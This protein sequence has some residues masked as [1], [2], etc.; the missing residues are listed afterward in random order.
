MRDPTSAESGN[1]YAKKAAVILHKYQEIGRAMQNDAG[2]WI[3]ARD[4]YMARQSHDMFK[5]RGKGPNGDFPAWRDY[6]TPRLDE[7]TFA[8]M[9]SA[10][11]RN[12]FL[13]NVW[14]ALSSG[15]HDTS[16]AP[17]VMGF[18]FTGPGSLAKRVSQERK[19]HF[20][21]ADAW[22][23]YNT[24]FGKGSVMDA[25]MA[26]FHRTARDTALMRT[27]G[28]NP[29]AMYD[30][31]KKR[32]IKDATERNDFAAVKGMEQDRN[33]RIFDT[34]T[35]KADLPGHSTSA[36]IA[37]GIRM[38]MQMSHLGYSMVA[39]IVDIGPSSAM[40]RHNGI[41]YAESMFKQVKGFFPRGADTDR[42]LTLSGVGND[43][44]LS[45][46]WSSVRAEDLML[47]KM[48]KA[49]SNF[50]K[51]SGLTLWTDMEKRSSAAMLMSDLA[52]DADKTL[53]QL[54]R[55]RQTTLRRY[56]IGPEEWD[57]ARA[58]KKTAADG[59]NYILP[60]HIEDQKVGDRFLNYIIDQT[61]EGMSEATAS[62]RTAVNLNTKSGTLIGETVRLAMQF[63]S[64]TFNYMMRSIG[65][66]LYRD[67]VDVGG[68]VKMIAATT[69]LGAISLTL[70][71]MFKGRN[72]RRPETIED[73]GAFLVAAMLKGGGLGLYGDFILGNNNGFGGGFLET[74][75][76][77]TLTTV[78]QVGRALAN[79]REGQSKR[80]RLE[81]LASDM[82][83]I[84]VTNT[85][86]LN[87]FYTQA[88][89]NYLI[90]YR[91]QEALNSGYLQRYE[92]KVQ[93]ANAQTHWLP[94]TGAL[95][96]WPGA[97]PR[98]PSIFGGP[99]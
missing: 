1:G 50:H 77:P 45:A 70:T 6:I 11:E 46:T 20:K 80:G 63:K 25:I 5:V 41:G 62:S 99:R 91:M 35:G 72:V 39:S 33:D 92:N 90:L 37:R 38:S 32:W 67:G 68:L 76:G 22:F 60:Q 93:K 14:N 52:Y 18:S 53:A 56:G 85:P 19:L 29:E 96:K 88:A 4:D 34:I 84:V 97:A 98:V 2:A 16:V 81:V 3:A 83:R 82:A 54:D 51:W 58:T 7:I 43:H 40:L 21:S 87:L 17:G 24:Q 9:E 89:V 74:I 31:V 28:T 69:A 42:L 36:S 44:M 26:G 8:G 79:L 94:P 27:F 23:D 55:R 78:A 49:V 59:H 95:E 61:R 75:A 66:E 73:A 30:K 47:G 65:R 13:R 64:F 10:G 48:S 57:I 86:Y 71:E 15:V 12:D